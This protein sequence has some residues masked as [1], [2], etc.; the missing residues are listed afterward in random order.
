MKGL[1]PLHINNILP[2]QDNAYTKFRHSRNKTGIKGLEPSNIDIKNQ[3][4]TFW[5]YPIKNRT[6]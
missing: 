2:P 6:N 5:L 1:E 4:L 3:R